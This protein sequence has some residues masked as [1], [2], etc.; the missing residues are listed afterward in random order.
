MCVCIFEWMLYMCHT[1]T[2]CNIIITHIYTNI[3]I[4]SNTHTHTH[5]YISIHAHIYTYIY[6]CMSGVTPESKAYE[7][8]VTVLTTAM[9]SLLDTNQ[10]YFNEFG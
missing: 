9:D 2:N 10:K 1:N 4:Y 3:Q 5:T 8:C 6:T 7:E